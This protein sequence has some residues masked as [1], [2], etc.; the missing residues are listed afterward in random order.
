MINGYE[1]ILDDYEDFDPICEIATEIFKSLRRLHTCDI[2]A[3]I[4]NLDGGLGQIPEKAVHWR[5][6]HHVAQPLT[7]PA[8]KTK[9][10]WQ[11]RMDSIYQEDDPAI[12]HEKLVLELEDDEGVFEGEDAKEIWIGGSS[13]P[14]DRDDFDRS[15]PW[16]GDMVESYPMYTRF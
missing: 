6:L 11:S 8:I 7:S 3:W 5:R 10:L 2:A 4:S 14:C 9:D 1:L 12:S 15:W 16:F 13:G